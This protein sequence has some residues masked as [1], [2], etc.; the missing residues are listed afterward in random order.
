MY[1]RLRI[2]AGRA[3]TLRMALKFARKSATFVLLEA[4]WS[5]WLNKCRFYWHACFYTAFHKN[6]TLWNRCDLLLGNGKI[7]N[8]PFRGTQAWWFHT[9]PSQRPQ[10]DLAHDIGERISVSPVA[11]IVMRRRSCVNF[12]PNW[13]LW[14][15]FQNHPLLVRRRKIVRKTRR[16]SPNSGYWKTLWQ[17]HKW[18]KSSN[19]VAKTT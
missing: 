18:E 10:K 7:P 3:A 17:V 4:I 14:C 13:A 5:L 9:W 2:Y 1:L 8:F 12:L 6:R 15:P 19:Q 11:F 16:L